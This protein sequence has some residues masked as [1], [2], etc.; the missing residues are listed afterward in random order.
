MLSPGNKKGQPINGGVK[1]GFQKK[2][3][4]VDVLQKQL[5]LE[6]PGLLR[7]DERMLR[8]E[9][10]CALCLYTFIL[11][12][13]VCLK[14]GNAEM[15]TRNYINLTELNLEERFMWDIV[16]F[17]TRQNHELQQMEFIANS[18]I[19]APYGV[20]LNYLFKKRNIFRD[21]FLCFAF[22]LSIEVFQLYSL[23]GGF[24]TEDLI[25]NTLG[26]FVG[27]IFY[28]LIFQKRTLKTCI[29]VC[30]V[31]NFILLPI[32]VYAL[33]T[34]LQNWELIISILNRTLYSPHLV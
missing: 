33:I 12:W 7:Y 5:K 31:A 19:F 2:E 28:Y 21:V 25:M 17:H 24:A 16:P 32:F 22:S 15:L 13:I 10:I 26:Y 34:T 30:R 14:F 4:N 9:V 11:L 1:M 18:L 29:W 6:T 27:L 23:L 8:L 3:K 20:L